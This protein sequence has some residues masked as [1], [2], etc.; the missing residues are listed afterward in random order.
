[1]DEP[2][3]DFPKRTIFCHPNDETEMRGQIKD[4]DITLLTSRYMERG[5]YLKSNDIEGK[6]AFSQSDTYGNVFTVMYKM[7]FH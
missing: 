4:E 7:E 2:E 5:R 6:P 1:M 3:L